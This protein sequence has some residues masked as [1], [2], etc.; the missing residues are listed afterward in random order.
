MIG[1]KAMNPIYVPFGIIL[2]LLLLP[3]HEVLHGVCYKKGQ[4]VYIGICLKKFAALMSLMPMLLGII[5]LA[6]FL[7][8]PP[9]AFLSGICIPMG[10]IGML[11]PMPDYMDV[12]I[13]CKQVPKGAFVHTQND[14]FYWY[15]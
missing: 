6:I 15:K 8:S 12:H 14:G 10:I 4:K 5:P 3:V 11:S 13:I 1:E 9:N 7:L 2:G